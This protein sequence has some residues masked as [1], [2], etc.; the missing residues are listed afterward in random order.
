MLPQIQAP[1]CLRNHSVSMAVVTARRT[2]LLFL[3]LL[4]DVALLDA[5]GAEEVSEVAK[6]GDDAKAQ[7]C[8]DGDIHG[9]LFKDLM[10]E[11]PG[12][13]SGPWAILLHGKRAK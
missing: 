8:H 6:Q 10:P 1:R 13:P 2:Y 4:G 9:R 5:Y 11:P 3:S 7:V 12:R